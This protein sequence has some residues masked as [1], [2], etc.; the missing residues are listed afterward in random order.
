MAKMVIA[1]IVK[2][3]EPV[4]AV[5]LSSDNAEEWLNNY[6]GTTFV[7][8]PEDD[9]RQDFIMLTDCIAIDVTG[10]DPMPGLGIGWKY[11]DGEWIPPV[12]GEEEG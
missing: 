4:N 8:D 6:D 7:L 12:L 2:D 9:F 1:V 5:L 11:V 10:L 3:T